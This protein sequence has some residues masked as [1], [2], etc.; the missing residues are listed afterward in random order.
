MEHV[1]ECIFCNIINGAVSADIVFD[2]GDTLFFKDI[3]PKAP[4]HIVGI[5]KKHFESL[6][7]MVG[8]DHLVM[9]KLMHD[10]TH[11]AREAGIFESGYRVLTNIGIHA[12]QEVPHVHFHILGGENLGPIR[13]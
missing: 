6:D 10:A 13:C 1:S 2:G 5:P 12:G 7:A 8:D 11:V 3:H 9:G 4:V